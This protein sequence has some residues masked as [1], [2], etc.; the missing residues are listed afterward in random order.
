MKSIEGSMAELLKNIGTLKRI[1]G[2]YDPLC[3]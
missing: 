1:I 2:Q 3:G